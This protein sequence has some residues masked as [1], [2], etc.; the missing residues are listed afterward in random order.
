MGPL[1]RMGMV[2]GGAI[3]KG[4]ARTAGYLT[5]EM[6]DIENEA[7]MRG[8][9][10]KVYGAMA[11]AGGSMMGMLREGSQARSVSLATKDSLRRASFNALSEEA[12]KSMLKRQRALRYATGLGVGIGVGIPVG[13]LAYGVESV[14]NSG[15]RFPGEEAS[16]IGYPG[17]EY[18]PPPDLNADGDLVHALHNVN[19]TGKNRGMR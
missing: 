4:V 15:R 17:T 14:L 6:A 8:V 16:L 13:T 12:Q 19:G 2:G 3:F 11:R 9:A 18:S 1:T 7:V 10:P 5:R